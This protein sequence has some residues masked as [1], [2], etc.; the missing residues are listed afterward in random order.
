MFARSLLLLLLVVPLFPSCDAPPPPTSARP[1]STAPPPSALPL[2]D[3]LEWQAD[4]LDA[5][6]HPL[7][8]LR[9]REQSA[10]QRFPNRIQ[11]ARA[12]ELGVTTADTEAGRTDLIASGRLVR[13]ADTTDYWIVRD[14]DFSLPY[15]TPDAERLLV[16]LGAR[17]HAALGALGLPPFRL[18][19]SS[20]LRTSDTQAALRARN[21]NATRGTSTHE[22]GTTVDVAYSAFAAPSHAVL[23]PSAEAD[24][25]LAQR[26]EALVL[27]RLAARRSRELQAILGRVLLDLQAEGLVMVTLEE[28]QPVYHMTV[29]RPFE[30]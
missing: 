10:L 14:L 17:F 6:L 3:T 13:L 29:A 12:R 4:D 27:E 8:L 18:E 22:Y 9:S 20:V 21:T 19:I 15:V 23:I 16:L 2:L 26:L 11:L 24:A 1:L 25:V 28:L 5:I 30:P 7:A